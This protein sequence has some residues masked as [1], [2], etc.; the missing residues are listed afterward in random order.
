M[1]AKTVDVSVETMAPETAAWKVYRM[2]TLMAVMWVAMSA[3]EMAVTTE[4]G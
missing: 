3:A 1:A 4:A 2:A